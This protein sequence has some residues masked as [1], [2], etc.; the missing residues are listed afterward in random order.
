MGD[1]DFIVLDDLFLVFLIFIKLKKNIIVIYCNI[2]NNINMGNV[3]RFFVYYL[4]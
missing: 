3:I 1:E 4:N 2:N